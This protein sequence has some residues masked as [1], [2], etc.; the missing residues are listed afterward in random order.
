MPE[1]VQLA[2]ERD[3]AVR[4]RD[5]TRLNADV[6]RPAAPGRYPAILL[7][8]PYDKSFGRIAYLQLDPMGAVSRGYALVIQDTRGRFTSEG[9]F[10]GFR[11]EC[12]DGY[13]TVEWAAQQP[14]SNG[15]VGMYGASYMGAT[16]WLAASARPPHL[17]YLVP[18]ITASD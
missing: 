11:Q 15:N 2:V 3:V 16:Q 18:L 10:Y 12:D 6:Y 7:R 1:T 13:D 4:M 17:K 5:G 14:W 8:T 9:E